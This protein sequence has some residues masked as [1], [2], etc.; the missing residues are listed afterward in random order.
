MDAAPEL[1]LEHRAELTQGVFSASSA[2]TDVGLT[3]P[4]FIAYHLGVVFLPVRNAADVVTQELA[5]LAEYNRLTYVAL[6][7][8][9]GTLFVAAL[10]LAGRRQALRWQN[11]VWLAVEG[12]LYALAMR[13]VSSF[14]VGELF[15]A[16]GTLA[17][18][19]GRFTGFVMSLGAGL[20]EEIAF[21]VLLFGVGLRC[22]RI[23]LAPKTRFERLR[24]GLVW[25]LACAVTFSGWHHFGAFADSFDSSVFVFR[26]VCGLV[27]TLIYVARGFAPVVW[28]HVVYDLWVLVW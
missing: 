17:E 27:F 23:L 16:G 10:L 4:I 19:E 24:L 26:T 11:F 1:D 3:V 21:R 12:V 13:L 20:Y 7:L 22:L 25:A 2:W 8:G 14:V 15:L 28:T 18:I 6:T 5:A 9:L